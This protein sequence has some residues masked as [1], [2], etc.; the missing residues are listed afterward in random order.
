[1]KNF[2]DNS[3]FFFFD[4][5][6]KILIKK[7]IKYKKY[8]LSKNKISREKKNLRGKKS[9]REKISNENKY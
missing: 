6:I 9:S 7:I 3:F 2:L 1:M 8:F 4:K 5:K